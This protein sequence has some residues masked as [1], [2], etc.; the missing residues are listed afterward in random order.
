MSANGSEGGGFKTLA[1]ES[2]KNTSFFFTHSLR[3]DFFYSSGYMKV[4]ALY[5][6]NIYLSL[7][8]QSG[9]R[10]LFRKP[11][12]AQ[13]GVGLHLTICI[14]GRSVSFFQYFLK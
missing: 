3:E 4:F 6:Y 7:C 5:I 14:I 8:S 13:Q 10:T 12:V 9:E 2:A 1:D 11:A